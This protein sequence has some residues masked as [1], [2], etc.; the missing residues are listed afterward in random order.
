MAK[1]RNPRIEA[2]MNEEEFQEKQDVIEQIPPK[3]EEDESWKKRYGDLRRHE[4]ERAAAHRAEMEKLQATMDTLRRQQ[5]NALAPPKSR[6]ELEA[7]IKAYPDFAAINQ[8]M[9]EDTVQSI[10]R[11]EG[12]NDLKST[13]REIEADKAKMKL[14]K[15]HPNCEEIFEDPKFHEWLSTQKQNHQDFIYKSFNVDDAALV[16]DRY[17][18]HTEKNSKKSGDDED[19]SRNAAKAVKTVRASAPEV[20]SG[21]YWF[22]ESQIASAGSKWWDANEE[23]IL[24]AQRKGKILM[25]ISGGAR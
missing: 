16:L 9:I 21:D 17:Q 11:K 22:T 14:K 2:E 15:L 10:L 8:A 18:L 23:K 24:E 1:Y 6:E 4:Q 19:T 3:D 7:W 12:I 13:Q 20:D 25:D 5:Q